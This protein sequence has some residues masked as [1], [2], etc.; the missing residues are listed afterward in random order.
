MIHTLHNSL[1]QLSVNT[2]GAELCSLRSLA[3]NIEYLWQA[4][5]EFWA[6]HAP[7]LFPI[8]GGLKHNLYVHEGKEYSLPR[9]G[10][11]RYNDKIVLRRKGEDFLTYGLRYD[12]ES[13][14]VY[15]FK[16][17]FEITFRLQGHQIVVHHQVRN[18]G[19]KSMYF[20]VGGHPAFS[21]PL[22]PDESYA[23]YYLEFEQN[24][25]VRTWVLDTG[26]QIEKEGPLM[27]NKSAVLPL[28][29]QLFD[30]DALIFKDLSSKRVRLK[31]RKSGQILT[32]RYDNWPYL[33]IWAKPGAS[34][35]CIEPWLGLADHSDTDQV[36]KN[37]IGILMLEAQAQFDASYMIEIEE[38]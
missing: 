7:V 20:S 23:D 21:C 35:V 2:T 28:H 14:E 13:L 1:L 9:H 15:P 10:F 18:L 11:I 26:G 34:F 16:F 33:G 4:D 37:K 8:V 17:D 27:L 36:L 25:T 3:S 5:P 19:K 22:H 12:A 6:N 38:G 32:V 30:N 24:E 29:D 31:S